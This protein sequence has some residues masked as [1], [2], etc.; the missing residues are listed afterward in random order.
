[1][2]SNAACLSGVCEG[3]GSPYP[4][5]DCNTAT[6]FRRPTIFAETRLPRY[7]KSTDVVSKRKSSTRSGTAPSRHRGQARRARRH[8]LWQSAV[9]KKRGP[10]GSPLGRQK[11]YSA[12]N[13]SLLK[14]RYG[15]EASRSAATIRMAT[16]GTRSTRSRILQ[17]W[18]TS[19]MQPIRTAL[20]AASRFPALHASQS[21]D[22]F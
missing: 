11:D 12:A 18:N 4:R 9:R 19:I 6:P 5:K 22:G 8:L 20:A 13:W 21:H 2:G 17:Q 3:Q 7:G 16:F 15:S 14:I 1:M 10:R